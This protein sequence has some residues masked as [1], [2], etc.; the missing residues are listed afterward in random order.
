M[1]HNMYCI[2]SLSENTLL[3]RKYQKIRK[4]LTNSK[5]YLGPCQTP[6]NRGG[7]RTAGIFKMEL[8]VIIVNG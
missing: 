4:I 8:F 7:S 3:K 6:L 5:A 1:H 2:L